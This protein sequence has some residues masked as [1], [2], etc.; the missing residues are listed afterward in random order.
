MI[1]KISVPLTLFSVFLVLAQSAS[2]FSLK[3]DKYGDMTLRESGVLGDDTEGKTEVKSEKVESEKKEENKQEEKKTEIRG[4]GMEVKLEPGKL[5]SLEIKKFS[6]EDRLKK[7]EIERN[8]E[9]LHKQLES[10][11]EL[12][13]KQVDFLKNQLEKQNELQKKLKSSSVKELTEKESEIEIGD[14]ASI[15]GKGKGFEI[16]DGGGRVQTDLGL[17]VDVETK[18]IS[19][20]GADGKKTE[21][22]KS[23]DDVATELS[24]NEVVDSLSKDSAGSAS[25]SLVNKGGEVVYEVSGDKKERLFGVLPVN[26]SKQVDVS[27]STGQVVRVNQ[28]AFSRFLDFF[29][30]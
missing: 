3:I 15:S 30:F 13:E 20:E 21:I 18:K 28:G 10:A 6:S 11:K 22:E 4:R 14:G 8:K 7:R 24:K 26:V 17:S 27:P 25:G 9:D 29:S 23:L 5:K 12:K 2:A 1:K 16:R 19:V